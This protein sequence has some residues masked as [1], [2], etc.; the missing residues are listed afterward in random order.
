MNCVG[1][2]PRRIKDNKFI[3]DI[4]WNKLGV[5]K[6]PV[7][8]NILEGLDAYVIIN[9]VAVPVGDAIGKHLKEKETVLGNNLRIKAEKLEDVDIKAW[10]D[11]F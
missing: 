4:G 1:K 8:D 9:S 5:G 10:K 7:K 2:C 6:D 11:V 3:Q